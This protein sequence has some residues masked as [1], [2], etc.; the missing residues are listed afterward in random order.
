[1][2]GLPDVLGAQ[3]DRRHARP[4]GSEPRRLQGAAAA[5]RRCVQAAD[6]RSRGPVAGQQ[7]AVHRGPGGHADAGPGRLGGRALRPRRGAGQRQRRPAVHHGH[8][9][10]RRV[11]RDRRW[12]GVQLQVRLPGRAARIGPDAVLRTGHRLRAGDG[13]AGLRQPEHVRDRACPEPRLV[14]REGPDV[15]VLELAAALA[16]VRDLRDLGRGR[17]QPP[18]VRRRGRRIRNRGRPHG[19]V[20]GHGVRAVLPGRIRQHDPAVLHGL[21]HVPGRLGFPDR[22]RAADLD[23]GLDLAGSQDILRGLVVR[24]V[25]RVV[26]ALPL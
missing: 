16:A 12:L 24:V 7:G 5:V 21:D 14:R 10:H 1:M 15:P 6:Q 9:V 11:W 18:P 20:L 3:D 8:H 25:P 26:P 4:H 2:R 23:S 13:A 19:R 17:N 22:H